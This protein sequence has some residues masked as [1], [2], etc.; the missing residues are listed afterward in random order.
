MIKRSHPIRT[1]AI[2]AAILF[3]VSACGGKTPKKED[4][5]FFSKWSKVAEKSKGYSPPEKA[6]PSEAEKDAP[7]DAQK[8]AL[9]EALRKALPQERV[10]IS[11]YDVSLPVL[12]RSL[13]RSAGLN[14][15]I[16]EKVIGQISLKIKE[17][18]WDEIFESLLKAHGLDYVWDGDVLRILTIEDKEKSLAQLEAEQR[19]KEKIREIETVEPLSTRVI[20]INYADAQN[21]QGNVEKFLSKKT[22]GDVIGAVM[23]D[24]HTNSLIVQAMKSDIDKIVSVVA[25]LD[26][27]TPQILIEAHIVEATQDTARELGIQWGGLYHGTGDGQNYY[28]TPGASTGGSTG[29]TIGQ[30]IAPE[31]GTAANFPVK[32]LASGITPDLAGLTLGFLSQDVGNYILNVQLSALEQEGKVNILSSPSITTLDNQTAVIE[33]GKEVPYQTVEDK[34]VKIEY[35]AAVLSLEVTP[36]VIEGKTLKLNINTKKDELDFANAVGGNPAITTK[37]A[38]TTVM[39]YNGQ[40]TVIGGLSRENKSNAETGVPGL[41]NIPLLGWLFKGESKAAQM[42]DLLIFITPHIL[43]ERSLKIGQFGAPNTE[44]AFEQEVKP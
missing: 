40:T 31:A 28:I 4:N 2:L 39:L 19:I 13:A 33:S 18:R 15:V 5:T 30:P 25:D 12:L 21:M 27:A 11:M 9:S 22:G 34:E 29:T 14:I 35:K 26:K 20:K 42:E 10:T 38:Q 17:A 43:E 8:T 36:H 44:D 7:S 6:Q 16:S 3:L 32:S 41:R 23:V 24:S 1:A 37:K